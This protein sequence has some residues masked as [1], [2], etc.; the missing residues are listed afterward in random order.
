M[1]FEFEVDTEDKH[2]VG[3]Y[4]SKWWRKQHIKVDGEIVQ[5][6]N[7]EF[8]YSIV[9][10]IVFVFLF[11][12]SL[13]LNFQ[14]MR[15]YYDYYQIEIVFMVVA[16]GWASLILLYFI[17]FDGLRYSL[18]KECSLKL[19]VGEKEEHTVEIEMTIPRFTFGGFLRDYNIIL[20]G[21]L[22]KTFSE[23][24]FTPSILGAKKIR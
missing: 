3:F 16:G 24:P 20:D 10:V 17:S 14:M 22:L 15:V 21:E 11:I 8:Y 18:F 5:K 13:P 9:G 1:E 6:N 2:M 23:K 7:V 12:L 4:R 19:T